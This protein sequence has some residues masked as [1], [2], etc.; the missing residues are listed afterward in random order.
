M[1]QHVLTEFDKNADRML[2]L[3]EFLLGINGTGAKNEQGWQVRH[4]YLK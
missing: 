2:S 3:E 1:R 4:S